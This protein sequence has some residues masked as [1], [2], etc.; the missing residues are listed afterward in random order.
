MNQ[1]QLFRPSELELENL[2]R[3]AGDPSFDY[4]L[5]QTSAK[6]EVMTNAQ[7]TQ[8]SDATNEVGTNFKAAIRLPS[9]RSV[10]D[11][12][13]HRSNGNRENPARRTDELIR[14]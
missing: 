3:R 6:A 12:G 10:F 9:G 13:Q 7:R 8:S 1:K 14:F 11:V 4:L 5:W 2:D